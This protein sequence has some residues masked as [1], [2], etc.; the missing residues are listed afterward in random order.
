MLREK[1]RKLAD[2]TSLRV[3]ARLTGVQMWTIRSLLDGRTPREESLQQLESWAENG[4]LEE[5]NG[6][7]SIW[8]SNE[9]IG[10]IIKK[11]L[12]ES[13]MTQG[14]LATHL[15]MPKGQAEVSRYVRG[16]RRPGY[17]KLLKIAALTGRG[18]DIFQN[19]GSNTHPS[20]ES[21]TVG[22][23]GDTEEMDTALLNLPDTSFLKPRARAFF[24]ETILEYIRRKWT[25]ENIEAAAALLLGY[26]TRASTLQSS[27]VSQ[28]ELSEE[29]QLSVLEQ[30][31]AEIDYAFKGRGPG[32]RR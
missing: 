12:E 2:A 28:P 20:A 5:G 14:E 16:K 25:S 22:G 17:E 7:E 8:K 31:K 23:G 4:N 32:S 29:M 26:F 1:V 19:T 9:E 6:V 27:G 18:V 10:R 13:G 30:S 3:A 11:I 15:G 21:P 24:N